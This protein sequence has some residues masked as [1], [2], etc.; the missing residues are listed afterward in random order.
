[1]LYQETMVSESHLYFSSLLLIT[2]ELVTD[3]Q[4]VLAGKNC[5]G[6]QE[7]YNIGSI[8]YFLFFLKSMLHIE[9]SLSTLQTIY[10]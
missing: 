4:I 5:K 7:D 2:Y 1:M 10:K 3:L 8:L 9:G 6:A